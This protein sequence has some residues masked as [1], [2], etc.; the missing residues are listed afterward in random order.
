MGRSKE[1]S[2]SVAQTTLT[3]IANAMSGVEWDGRVMNEVADLVH[4]AGYTIR[5]LDP[6]RVPPARCPSC[7]KSDELYVHETGVVSFEYNAQRHTANTD[8]ETIEHTNDDYT[9][10]CGHC[11][12]SGSLATFGMKLLDW[13][14]DTCDEDEED[15][16]GA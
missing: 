5:P 16:D 13:V 12:A 3:K 11:K 8:T 15:D 10:Y 4:K 9:A 7:G 6:D 2:A 14:D 1:P